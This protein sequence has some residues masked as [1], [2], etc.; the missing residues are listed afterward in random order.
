VAAEIHN[1][2]WLLSAPKFSRVVI[3]EDG[4]PATMVAPDPRAFALHKLWVRQQDDREPVKKSR[5]QNQALA[6]AQLIIRY[7]PQYRFRTAELR[8]FP[9][10]VVQI[11]KAFI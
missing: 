4:F 5:D 11:A 10:D 6:V 9:A 3:G 7:L 8:M 2:Q 1:L